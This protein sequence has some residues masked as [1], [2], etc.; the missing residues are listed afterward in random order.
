MKSNFNAAVSLKDK[1]A[2][3]RTI[4]SEGSSFPDHSIVADLAWPALP[5]YRCGGRA[6]EIGAMISNPF[7]IS[8]GGFCS[9]S[10]MS[11]STGFLRRICT[12]VKA[13]FSDRLLSSR[14][15]ASATS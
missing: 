10:R 7:M 6:A 15:A 9:T 2:T 8:F 14:I 13:I 3:L 1:C 11:N 4:S 5:Y 12:G